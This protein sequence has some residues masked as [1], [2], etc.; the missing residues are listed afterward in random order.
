MSRHPAPDSICSAAAPYT[1]TEFQRAWAPAQ[2]VVYSRTIDEVGPNARIEREFDPA[3]AR[4]LA[5]ASGADVAIGGADLGGQALR[6]GIVDV[7]TLVLFPV[8]IGAG[9]G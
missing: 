8:I 3:S 5:D 2:K 9:S 1:E 6:A 4:A 7:L